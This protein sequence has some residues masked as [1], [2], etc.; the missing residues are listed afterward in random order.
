MK[1][2]LFHSLSE[3]C[4]IVD[5]NA[6]LSYPD[7]IH[8]SKLFLYACDI[9]Q[10][11]FNSYPRIAEPKTRKWTVV[12]LLSESTHQLLQAGLTSLAIQQRWTACAGI[13]KVRL[14]CDL[15]IK[16]YLAAVRFYQA[17][18]EKLKSS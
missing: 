17:M 12:V 5:A 11:S 3:T 15:A 18:D 16:I 7:C 13:E 6:N 10:S 2:L 4:E 1:Y 14:S 8:I 9:L